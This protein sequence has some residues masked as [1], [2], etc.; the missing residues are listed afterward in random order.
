MR[1]LLFFRFSSFEK[2]IN[3]KK[4]LANFWLGYVDFPHA[5]MI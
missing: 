3:T 4:S 1:P 2:E 5:M